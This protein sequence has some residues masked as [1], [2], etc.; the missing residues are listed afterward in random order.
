MPKEIFPECLFAS[1]MPILIGEAKDAVQDICYRNQQ[2]I[3]PS[4]QLVSNPLFNL[5]NKIPSSS[6][7]FPLFNV[8]LVANQQ[9]T[10]SAPQ[11][12]ITAGQ[13][14][15]IEHENRIFEVIA[16]EGSTSGETIHIIVAKVRIQRGTYTRSHHLP[17]ISLVLTYA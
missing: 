9:T 15:S 16:P 11:D 10:Y 1:N 7:Q 3:E 14:F 17:S 13:K 12:G 8:F 6:L 2:L 4:P 5:L